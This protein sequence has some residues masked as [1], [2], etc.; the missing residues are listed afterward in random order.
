MLQVEKAIKE[1]ERL[2]YIDPE[3]SLQEKQKGNEAFS[4]GDYPTAIRCYTEA[5]KRNPDDP[6]IYSNRAACYTKLAEFSMA[7]KDC[8]ECLRLDPKFSES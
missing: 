4:K 5:I 2:A 1:Q 8:D 3:L 6:K 7:L